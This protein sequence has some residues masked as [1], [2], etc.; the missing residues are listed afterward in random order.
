ML[1]NLDPALLGGGGI[2]PQKTK[3]TLPSKGMAL[4]WDAGGVQ[5][6][7]LKAGV[8]VE[9]GGG[10]LPHGTAGTPGC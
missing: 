9:H 10:P 7:G 5:G 8:A 3:K 1:F 6:G 4:G 2:G